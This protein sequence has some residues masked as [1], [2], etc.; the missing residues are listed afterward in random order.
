VNTVVP[1]PASRAVV[2]I[3]RTIGAV[4]IAFRPLR[5]T[6]FPLLARWLEEP[7]VARWWNHETSPEALERDF[8]PSIDGRDPTEMFVASADGRAYGFIQRYRLS[9]EPS[10]VAEL[11]RLCTVPPGAIS[12]DYLIGE[13]DMRGRGLGAAMIAQLTQGEDVLVPVAAGNVASW[14]ALERAGFVRVAE[15]ELEP[16]NP[17]DPPLHYVYRQRGS[18]ETG[19]PP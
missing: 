8:G 1:N 9:D 13:P 7:R 14:R 15:G 3:A 2:F 18:S 6:D 17:I 4:E 11:S 19:A 12:V 16:D 10:Y 5:R